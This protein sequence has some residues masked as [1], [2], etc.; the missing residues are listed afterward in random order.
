MTP[1]QFF[2]YGENKR[3]YKNG[4]PERLESSLS[5]SL[6]SPEKLHSE[7]GTELQPPFGEISATLLLIVGENGEES[8]KETLG[9]LVPSKLYS[10][11]KN[12][13]Y[14]FR[15]TQWGV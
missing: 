3:Y 10:L 9:S 7:K 12:I 15:Y 8:S 4:Y 5:I 2:S 1:L 13:S 14:I 11:S 6:D